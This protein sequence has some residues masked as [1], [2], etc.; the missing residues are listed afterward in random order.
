MNKALGSW[1]PTFPCSLV[2]VAV[3]SILQ[4][5]CKCCNTTI[6]V[7]KKTSYKHT[8]FSTICFPFKNVLNNMCIHAHNVM[9]FSIMIPLYTQLTLVN[10][11]YA[12]SSGGNLSSAL[13]EGT[14]ICATCQHPPR[15]NPRMQQWKASA[16]PH[17]PMGKPESF[18]GFKE[19][20][21]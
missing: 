10:G 12:L 21:C 16:L 3:K 18:P 17:Y 4:H 8:E 20:D 11:L 9:Y 5:S 14:R 19:H 7:N 2:S 13:V 15:I 1:R 6:I